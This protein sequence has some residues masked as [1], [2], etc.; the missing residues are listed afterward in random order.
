MLKFY[1]VGSEVQD[2]L[3]CGL[4]NFILDLEVV[5]TQG[6]HFYSKAYLKK[7]FVMKAKGHFQ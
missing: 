3:N 4:N 7:S 2:N 6:L 1:W 5:D